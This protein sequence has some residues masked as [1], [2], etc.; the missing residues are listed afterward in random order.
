[1]LQRDHRGRRDPHPARRS[2]RLLKED[3]MTLEEQTVVTTEPV[4]TSAPTQVVERVP[5]QATTRTVV[6]DDPVRNVFAATQMIQTVIWAVVVI[7]LLVVAL[8]ALH[9]YAHLF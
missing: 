5:V 9:V 4:E 7:V 1:H 2:P 3:S 6:S 8:M